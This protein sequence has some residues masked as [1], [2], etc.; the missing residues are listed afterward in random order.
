[1][2]G[3]QLVSGFITGPYDRTYYAPSFQ[4]G[5]SRNIKRSLVS[6][7]GGQG[8]NAGNGTFLASKDQFVSGTLSFT[9]QSRNLSFAGAYTRLTS[10]A[11]TVS[12]QYTTANLSVAYGFNIVR[13]VNGNLRY[14]FIHY[15]NLYQL[16]G[17]NESRFSFGFS[18]DSKSVPL[19]LF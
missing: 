16:N 7:S 18:F 8:I 19:T 13:Y 11:N 17:L 6:I 1:L 5:V 4:L 3:Q 10:I 12:S 15:D 2:L 14:D 9:H